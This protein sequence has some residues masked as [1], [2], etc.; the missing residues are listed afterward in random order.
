M[1]TED[2]SISNAVRQLEDKHPGISVEIAQ[3]I[4]KAIMDERRRCAVIARR[5]LHN[6]NCLL[7]M[8]PL[9]EAA[10]DIARE[11]LSGEPA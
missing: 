5:H 2:F 3:D 8:P 1:D 7:T 11:V 6:T 4:G 9:S 10:A